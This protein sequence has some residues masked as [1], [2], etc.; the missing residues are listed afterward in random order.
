MSTTKPSKTQPSTRSSQKLSATSNTSAASSTWSPTTS[1]GK[2]NHRA[3][4]YYWFENL[5]CSVCEQESILVPKRPRITNP[6]IETIIQL[7]ASQLP[8]LETLLQ[9]PVV[10]PPEPRIRPLKN[11]IRSRVRL[12]WLWTRGQHERI[13][14]WKS[15]VKHFHTNYFNLCI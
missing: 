5:V 13:W 2:R 6:V 3:P 9:L 7:E 14:R 1:K 10:N 4:D 12:C 11:A 8:L 15:N